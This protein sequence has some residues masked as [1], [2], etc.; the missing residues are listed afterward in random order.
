MVAADYVGCDPWT[1][2]HVDIP[3]K[4]LLGEAPF[5]LLGPGREASVL[6]D[7]E[8]LH[9]GENRDGL[10]HLAEDLLQEPLGSIG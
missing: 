7:L 5:P 4:A 8:A 6:V 3:G 9:D 1:S 10:L 2:Q